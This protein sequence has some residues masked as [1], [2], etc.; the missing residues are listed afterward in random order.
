MLEQ[1]D[2]DKIAAIYIVNDT[3]HPLHSEYEL[4]IWTTLYNIFDKQKDI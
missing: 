3:E 4:M 1:Q 2:A